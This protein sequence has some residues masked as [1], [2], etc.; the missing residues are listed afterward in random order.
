MKFILLLYGSL[1][2]GCALVSAQD[3]LVNN[4]PVPGA[5]IKG[6]VVT[7]SLKT[8]SGGIMVSVS[9][10][11][12]MTFTDSLGYF[13]LENV[14]FGRNV[15]RINK[16][17]LVADTFP[18][19]VDK[20]DFDLG[21]VQIKKV[22]W[23]ADT[24]W[25]QNPVI[26]FD[27]NRLIDNDGPPYLPGLF[28][29]SH[30]PFLSVA[31]FHLLPLNFRF[32]GYSNSS[33]EVYMNGILL[34]DPKDGAFLAA[35]LGGLNEVLRDKTLSYGLA[36]DDT[37]FGGLNGSTAMEVYASEQQQKTLLTYGNGNRSYKNRIAVAYHTGLMDNGWALSVAE[38]KRWAQEGYVPGTSFQ[39]Y[40]CYLGVSKRTGKKGFLHFN[41]FGAPTVTAGAA[42]VTQEAIDLAGS[43]YYNPDWGYQNGKKRNA[44]QQDF[45]QPLFLV[46]YVY[47][48][49]RKTLI[50]L[51]AA[52]KTGHQGSSSLDWYNAPDPRP[53]YYQN[54]PSYWTE[55]SQPNPA[56]AAAYRQQW[57]HDEHVAQIDWAELYDRNRANFERVNGWEGMRSRYVLGEDR[58]EVNK[59]SFALTLKK[60]VGTHFRFQAGALFLLEQ[61][62]RYRRLLDL[63]GGDF[64]VNLNQFAENTFPGHASFN[65][66]DLN[67]P[68]KIV[69]VGD[70]Y[71]YNYGTLFKK[72]MAWIQGEYSFYK[73]SFFIAGRLVLD[74]F[75]RTGFYK[76][77]LFPDDSYGPSKMQTSYTYQ[78]KG[79]GSY[80]IN[81]RHRLY[82][83]A[84]A[85]TQ[86]PLFEHTFVSPSTRNL[87]V[88]GPVAERMTSLEGG[89]A[90]KSGILN[91]RVT[92][93]VTD[94]KDAA[95]IRRFYYED[96][97]SFVNYVMQGID[98]RHTG[99]ELAFQAQI[100]KSWSVTFAG[101][102]MQVFYTSRPVVSIYRD[103]DTTRVVGKTTVYGKDYFAGTGPQSACGLGLTYRARRYGF[104]SLNFNYLDRNYIEM[105]P[106]RLTAEA[107]DL[108][109]PESEQWKAIRKQEQLPAVFTADIAGGRTFRPGKQLKRLFR[110]AAFSVNAG[111]NNI[112]NNKKAISG[113]QQLRFDYVDKNP[114]QF[115]TK[116]RYGSGVTYFINLKMSF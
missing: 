76:N 83:Y 29:S 50:S 12:I 42:A 24:V 70:R 39:S 4:N 6:R 97:T 101:A 96:Y 107:I 35:Q 41:A 67:Q 22:E 8:G 92:A 46:Q 15:L 69:G 90:L 56:M 43:V 65:Q 30:D 38:A 52:F 40:T 75:N 103:N 60:E 21:E 116:Y 34:N 14:P 84:A 114:D 99:L 87:V 48:P 115:P 13:V 105:N 53:D 113:N 73:M 64:Y 5:M 89:Y 91:G 37:Y 17:P 57:L 2:A 20:R 7:D 9:S 82:M 45:S 16:H 108:L 63:L 62:E 100:T 106:T 1:I 86:P 25:Q 81:K 47:R 61:A 33:L 18:F 10:S 112:L 74:E 93:F 68:D 78:L 27:E 72:G 109:A 36:A 19:Y 102:Y 94:I 111:I 58:E 28:N 59:Y 85:M 55:R 80:C 54:M 49:D 23:P 51:A 77:G 79:G 11:G 26:A 95:R 66:V 44:R 104:V 32:R 98:I 3:S 88:A 71:G 31:A 110:N